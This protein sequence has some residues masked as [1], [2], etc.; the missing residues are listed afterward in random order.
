MAGD[1]TTA[2]ERARLPR[3]RTAA[4]ADRPGAHFHMLAPISPACEILFM[5]LA[6]QLRAGRPEEKF[7]GDGTAG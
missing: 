2:A 3:I 7:G 5:D 4:P 6:R 1:G